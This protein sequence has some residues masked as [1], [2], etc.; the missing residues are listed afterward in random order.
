MMI[1]NPSPLHLVDRTWRAKV[2]PMERLF[3]YGT[4][5]DESVQQRLI[6]RVVELTPNTLK[7][8]AVGDLTTPNG[9]H[10]LVLDPKPDQLVEGFTMEVSFW[11]LIQIDE[12]QKYIY[13]KELE[14]SKKS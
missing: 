14:K 10:Y 1:D 9:N 4:L 12:Y 7:G 8:Y 13:S 11:E 5:K 2:N 6:G 3:V